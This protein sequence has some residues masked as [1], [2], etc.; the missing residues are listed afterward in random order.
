MILILTFLVRQHHGKAWRVPDQRWV[1]ELGLEK[2]RNA[3][4]STNSDLLRGAFLK[5]GI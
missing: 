1:L 4:K 5:F 3:F 2:Q